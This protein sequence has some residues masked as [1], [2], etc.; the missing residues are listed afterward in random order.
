MKKRQFMHFY[1]R[2]FD[3]ILKKKKKEIAR[4]KSKHLP[5]VR[6]LDDDRLKEIILEFGD[7]ETRRRFYCMMN[8]QQ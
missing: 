1:M 3:Q 6:L 2:K 8:N 4:S 7:K 5:P